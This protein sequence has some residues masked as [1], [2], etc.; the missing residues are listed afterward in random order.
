MHL[1]PCTGWKFVIFCSEVFEIIMGRVSHGLPSMSS[2]LP[3]G[4]FIWSFKI[5]VR[6]TIGESWKAE[7]DSSTLVWPLSSKSFLRDLVYID[8]LGIMHG[9]TSLGY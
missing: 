1:V 8:V 4:H 3:E 2:T 7:E 6:L 9:N 5:N